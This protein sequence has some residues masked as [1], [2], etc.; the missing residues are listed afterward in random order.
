MYVSPLGT[1]DGTGSKDKP[2]GSVEAAQ[3]KI[4]AL[5]KSGHLTGP[6]FVNLGKGSYKITRPLEFKPED[7]G[8]EGSPITY[9]AEEGDTVTFHGGKTIGNWKKYKGN[10]WMAKVFP[11]GDTSWTFR[12]LYVNGKLQT[13]ARTPNHA[14]FRVTGFPDGGPEVHYQTR[15][16][17]FAYKAGDLNPKWK[18]ITDIEIIVYHFWTDTH[19]PVKSIDGVNN[20]VSF[21]HPSSKVFTDDFTKEG[22]RY[23]VENVW[24]GLDTPGE[25]YL[26][27]STG[28]LYYYPPAGE[29]MTKAEVIAPVTKAFINIEGNALNNERVSYLN[30]ENIRFSY[31]NFELP[32]GDANDYQGSVTIPAAIHVTGAVNCSFKNC[33]VTNI[34]NWALNINKGSSNIVVEQCR[35]T[36]LAAGG[37]KV[38]GVNTN[39]HPLL[40]TGSNRIKNNR[41]SHYGEVFPSAVGVLLIHTSENEV[42]HNEIHDGGY[43]GISVG[44]SWGYKRSM[45]INNKIEFNLIH[46]IGLKGLLSDM[47]GIYTLGNSPGTTVR[48]NIIHD[49]SANHY[50]G[51]GIY[52]DE[53]STHLLIE[54]NLVYNTKFAPFNI[55]YAK[56]L[57]VRNNIF[58]LGKLEQIN[59]GRRELHNSVYFENNI[60]YWKEGSLLSGNWKDTTYSR[61]ESPMHT[62]PDS[63]TFTFDY[64]LYYNPMQPLDSIRFQDLTFAGWQRR[65]KDMHS[66]YSDP[67]FVDA[68]RFNFT[69]KASSPAFKMGFKPIDF[70]QVGIVTGNR[71]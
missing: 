22:A 23:V 48:N 2:F 58:A 17:R 61:Y 14:F 55:H 15:S 26:N 46:H 64:N 62:G 10:I 30:F 39:E 11:P 42:M 38:Q 35:F 18:N 31:T 43:T 13:R 50:G 41:I 25:W 56:E 40:R 24:E 28:M 7:S 60:V 63:S 47:G 44:W 68:D 1:E 29:D 36:N 65:G 4:R 45:S 8:T 37:I 66:R 71:Q 3:A 57:L 16:S 53:G 6:L 70:S 54:N 49:V 20:I 19:L 67:Q 51:W 59:R 9:R 12:Q 32:P 5:K 21:R 52:A 69:L 33:T 34:G 27:K